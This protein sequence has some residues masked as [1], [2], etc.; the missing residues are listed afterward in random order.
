MSSNPQVCGVPENILSL[1]SIPANREALRRASHDPTHAESFTRFSK[2][3]KPIKQLLQPL[4]SS[5]EH[6]VTIHDGQVHDPLGA[7]SYVFQK[8]LISATIHQLGL[9]ELPLSSGHEDN[10][11]L[12]TTLIVHTGAQPNNSPHAGTLV[13]FF[14]TFLIAQHIRMHY[15][16]I[17][18]E[19]RLSAL[20]VQ[21]IHNFTVKVQL[22]LVDTAPD[23]AKTPKP[24]ADGIHYQ[25][26]LRSGDLFPSLLPDYKEVM[27]LAAEA[28]GGKVPYEIKTQTNLLRM[29]SIPKI[30]EEIVKNREV[31]GKTL[32]PETGKLAMR[33]ACSKD[34]C[35]LAEKHG[36][37]N[38][39]LTLPDGTVVISF[40][41]SERNHGRH[42]IS[43]ANPEE[44]ARLEF[45]TPLRNLVRTLAYGLDTN[46]SRTVA[47]GKGG[48]EV[49]VH[50]RVTGMDYAGTYSEQLLWRPLCLLPFKIDP[51]V[52]LYAPLIVDWAGSK[53]SKSLYVKDSAYKYLE[54]Q[55]MSYL[56]SYGK[57]KEAG[58]DP[59]VL[60]ELVNGWVQEP[61]KMFR[62]YS[63]E[64]LHQCFS[65]QT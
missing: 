17:L 65:K 61:K 37:H 41:C 62:S 20:E 47:R 2:A 43:T 22:N 33:A 24:G 8:S 45:N 51:P 42:E 1:L 49:R 14:K 3:W 58:K 60:F 44:V 55:N 59:M 31:I 23:N 56:L 30:I 39:Y 34:G 52:I 12:P 32:S 63:I 11:L 57:M 25:R 40:V 9:P 50:M 26:S 38:K 53:L 6:L 13:V 64:Y 35:G 7:G 21:W 54:E 18:E 29:T 48:G 46:E 5:F 16:K 36:L 28:V 27:A 4:D 19:G 15:D 10:P